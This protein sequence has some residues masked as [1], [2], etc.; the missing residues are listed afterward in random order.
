M[1]TAQLLLFMNNSYRP[2]AFLIAKVGKGGAIPSPP[3]NQ[4][5][6]ILT[7]LSPDFHRKS[8]LTKSHQMPWILWWGGLGWAVPGICT[9]CTFSVPEHE[10]QTE[11]ISVAWEGHGEHCLL[12]PIG[13]GCWWFL[14]AHCVS[15]V[16][17]MRYSSL[18]PP[19][20]WIRS[21]TEPIWLQSTS[22]SCSILAPL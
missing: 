6:A 5:K 8:C 12:N 3:K 2:T 11:F 17:D 1:A 15:S 18:Y 22:Q 16:K 4:A 14:P 21:G 20:H 7:E 10:E 13:L 19:I 9:Y